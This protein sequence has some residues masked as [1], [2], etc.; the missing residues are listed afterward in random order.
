LN[1]IFISPHQENGANDGTDDGTPADQDSCHAR[2]GG[3]SLEKMNAN[4][5]KPGSLKGKL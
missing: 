1:F 2:K 5:E 4:R 3:L